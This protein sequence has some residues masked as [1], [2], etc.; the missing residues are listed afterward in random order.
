MM[1]FFFQ[2]KFRLVLQTSFLKW[3]RLV[4][5]SLDHQSR[6][7]H[8]SLDHKHHSIAQSIFIVAKFSA[9]LLKKAW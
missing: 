9:F 3:I 4:E 8:T 5:S 6:S 2:F 1:T 7:L